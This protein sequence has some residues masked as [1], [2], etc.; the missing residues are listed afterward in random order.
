M[1]E[2][3][4]GNDMKPSYSD[5]IRMALVRKRAF[6]R[7]VVSRRSTRDLPVTSSA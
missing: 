5:C 4:N 1:M 6:G 7:V 3:R 2:L